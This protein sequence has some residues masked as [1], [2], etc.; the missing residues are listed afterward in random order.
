[1]KYILLWAFIFLAGAAPIVVLMNLK[2]EPICVAGY[3]HIRDENGSTR[4]LLDSNGRGIKCG[5]M[6]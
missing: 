5:V 6:V 1:M 4:Q 3:L 2:P